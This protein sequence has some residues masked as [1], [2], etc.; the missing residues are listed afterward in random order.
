MTES[1]GA[2]EEAT[3][4]DTPPKKRFRREYL[5]TPAIV[6]ALV[7]LVDQ[8]DA[9][10]V[11][12]LLPILQEEWHL[13]DFKLGMLGFAFV[14]LNA[15]ATI[16]A[17][18]VADRYRRTRIIGWTLASW[19]VL[20]LFSAAA[21]NFWNLF[22]ARAIM[23]IGQSVDDPAA[24]S[25]LGDYYPAQVRGRIF[26]MQQ[27]SLFLGGG[28]GLGLGGYVGSTF[29]WRW[30]FAL[31]GMPGSLVAFA[32]FKLREPRR[33]EAD[34]L[35]GPFY[36]KSEREA[37]AD[38]VRDLGRDEPAA[39]PTASADA[40][41]KVPTTSADAVA[42]DPTPPAG[43]TGAVTK[44][45]WTSL[46]QFLREA[47][48]SLISEMKMIWRIRTMR[49]IL[50]GIGTLL[51][52]VSGTAYW[53]A[54]YHQR[55]SGMSLKQATAV[56]AGV[57]SIAGLIG[58][59]WGGS[60]ADRIYGRGYQGRIVMTATAIMACTALFV[61]SYSVPW[62]GLR[63]ALQFLGV[64]IISSAPPA[65][66][67]AMMDVVPAES[68]GVS[69]SA[70]ALISTVCGAAAAPPIVGLLADWTSLLGAFYIIAPPIFVGT[71]ILLHARKTIVEDAQAIVRSMFEAQLA[72]A[73]SQDSGAGAGADAGTDA[74]GSRPA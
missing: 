49:Y 2:D 26:S 48:T 43:T 4:A 46:R 5:T 47:T 14:F 16:P 9:S 70:F 3:E 12:G 44:P 6:L 35:E 42:A 32:V 31:V 51:F 73:A 63:L 40:V 17:G 64:G 18:W 53:L 20:S 1:T 62:V 10:I 13:S 19:S 72:A 57:L 55:Y 29:G 15:I 50:V 38:D 7:N 58:T 21:V 36:R 23:G 11:R 71:F 65:L 30:A 68:R 56:T 66:R 8:V 69:A 74:G 24:T 54:V 22:F 27:V 25:L 59:L 37:N 45:E 41:A 67:A 61:V 33:G 52:T 34:E 60:I 28:I 39:D